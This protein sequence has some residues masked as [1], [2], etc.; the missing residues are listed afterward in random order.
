MRNDSTSARA[1][2]A[3]R[4]LRP[5]KAEEYDNEGHSLIR[6]DDEPTD[7]PDD[8]AERDRKEAEDAEYDSEVSKVMEKERNRRIDRQG[9]HDRHLEATNTCRERND[10]RKRHPRKIVEDDDFD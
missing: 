3:R 9:E 5:R 8:W 10:L 1:K 2:Q 7:G 4:D 6:Y